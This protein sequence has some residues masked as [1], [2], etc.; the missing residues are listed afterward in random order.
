[1]NYAPALLNFLQYAPEEVQKKCDAYYE[2]PSP[3][4][5]NDRKRCIIPNKS[6][7]F[8]NGLIFRDNFVG[9]YNIIIYQKKD[10]DRPIYL[11]VFETFQKLLK[12]YNVYHAALILKHSLCKYEREN[13][14]VENNY[15][16]FKYYDRNILPRLNY[17][18]TKHRGREGKFIDWNGNGHQRE[19]DNILLSTC[20]K[21]SYINYFGQFRHQRPDS[22]FFDF[23]EE[24]DKF[25]LFNK[26]KSAR[27]ILGKQKEGSDDDVTE[28]DL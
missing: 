12:Y 11:N 22:M 2:Y 24:C 3:E 20:I 21:E 17:N 13:V 26:K 16:H 8:F 10:W 23:G 1:M 28:E 6:E 19:W 15:L 9:A 5:Q 14:L 18:A 7:C 4:T 25:D 27:K